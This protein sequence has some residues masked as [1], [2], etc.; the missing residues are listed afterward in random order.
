MRII[1]GRLKG[2]RLEGPRGAGVRP[3][4]DSLRETLFNIVGR[5]V[6]GARVLDAFAGTG[7]VG[8]EALSRGARHVT[9][10]ESNRETALLLA[11]NVA[12]C[13][14]SDA[15]MIVRDEFARA[16][17]G[18]FDLVWLDPPYDTR[19]LESV[20]TRA[21]ELVEVNGLVV[22]EHSRRRAM[23]E[24]AAPLVRTRVLVAGD[25]ALS[26]FARPSV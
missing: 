21:V 7:A 10:V 16:R 17:L 3:T 26:F 5:T 15:C 20:L 9:F 11:E 25:S 8:L 13:Q 23:P 12:R 22:V 2:R 24:L 19:D 14:G 18:R 4:S 1:A 6:D